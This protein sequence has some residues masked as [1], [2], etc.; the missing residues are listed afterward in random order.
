M[1]Q[2]RTS[3]VSQIRTAT[4]AGNRLP[5]LLGAL[6]GAIAPTGTYTVLHH[7]LTSAPLADQ[8]LVWLVG[9]GLVFSALTV[10]RWAHIAFNS[11]LKALGWTMLVEGLMVCAPA[12]LAWLSGVCLA[13]LV[14]INATACACSLVADRETEQLAEREERAMVRAAKRQVASVSQPKAA[15][16]PKSVKRPKSAS[17]SGVRA[18]RRAA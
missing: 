3:V 5:A 1:S 15:A 11:R 8:P 2:H 14:V 7:G 12:H 10:V 17:K 18:V 9:G 6:L 16:K 4:S 13:Y